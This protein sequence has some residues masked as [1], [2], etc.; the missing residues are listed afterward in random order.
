M[1][2]YMITPLLCKAPSFREMQ[3]TSVDCGLLTDL[4]LLLLLCSAA[5]TVDVGRFARRRDLHRVDEEIRGPSV[6]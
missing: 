3:Y 4:V 5:L 2:M 1:C 6:R